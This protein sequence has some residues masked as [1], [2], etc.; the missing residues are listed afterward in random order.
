[1]KKYLKWIICF[2]SFSIFIF[3]SILVLHK[4]D[5]YI[6]SYVYN[7]IFK[8]IN[9][10]NTKIVKIMTYLGSGAVVITITLL[11]LLLFKN[12]KYGLYMSLNLILITLC[13]LILKPI[14]SRNRPLDI[15]LIEETG[16]SFPSGHSLTAFSFYGFIIY[17]VCTSN[18][19]TKNKIIISSLLSIIILITGVSRVY[20]GVHF[21]TDV[22]G[23]FS[24]ALTY[25]II[26]ISIIKKNLIRKEL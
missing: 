14:F 19:R 17:L 18:I 13:Q 5:I 3:L 1:M 20:L 6:D 26:Y 2:I 12:K 15:S 8:I 10:D 24:F 22:I 25:L 9:N 21:F 11:T 7:I 4:N 23:A 16:Y